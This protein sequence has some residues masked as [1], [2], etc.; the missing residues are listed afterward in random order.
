MFGGTALILAKLLHQIKLLLSNNGFM[1]ILKDKPVLFWVIHTFLV[2]VGLHMSAEIDC[3]SAVFSLFK[4][5]SNGFT[6]ASYVIIIA[7][8]CE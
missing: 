1:G 2:F 4:N 5:M 8:I 3:V 7:R 6:T